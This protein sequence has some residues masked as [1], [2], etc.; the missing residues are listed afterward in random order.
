MRHLIP[1]FQIGTWAGPALTD[2]G[3]PHGDE[4]RGFHVTVQWLGLM[5]ECAFCRVVRHRRN[6]RAA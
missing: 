4:V 6:G 3:T 5:A 1:R 2:D